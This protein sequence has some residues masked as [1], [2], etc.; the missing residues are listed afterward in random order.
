MLHCNLISLA[1]IIPWSHEIFHEFH[2]TFFHEKKSV[3]CPSLHE[4]SWNS[5]STVIRPLIFILK[6]WLIRI[7]RI[8]MWTTE[9]LDA[10]IFKCCMQYKYMDTGYTVIDTWVTNLECTD[11]NQKGQKKNKIIWHGNFNCRI[12]I[13]LLRFTGMYTKQVVH[14]ERAFFYASFL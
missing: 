4:I 8:R 11:L 2:E 14:Y 13:P 9:W 5:V 1:K 7:C 10:H 3:K 12:W 6:F